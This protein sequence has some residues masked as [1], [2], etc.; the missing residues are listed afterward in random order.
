MDMPNWDK[1]PVL[2]DGVNVEGV[3]EHIFDRDLTALAK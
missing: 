1:D 3:I 2:E